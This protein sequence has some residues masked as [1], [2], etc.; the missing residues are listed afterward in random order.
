MRKIIGCQQ[1]PFI[2]KCPISRKKE[3][4]DSMMI[5]RADYDPDLIDWEAL[6]PEVIEK[7]AEELVAFH[8]EFRDAFCRVEQSILGLCY[9]QGLLGEIR[10]KNIEAIALKYLGPSRVR[11]LQKFI[12]NYRW[13]DTAV[14]A[15]AQAML[16]GLIA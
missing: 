13:D 10:R 7:M 16:S 5:Q 11:S 1:R 12:T 14:L 9:L 2:W 8:D 6:T 4:A 3:K 15:R